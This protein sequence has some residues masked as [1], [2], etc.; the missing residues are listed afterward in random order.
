[1]SSGF[2][3]LNGFETEQFLERR[4]RLRNTHLKIFTLECRLS[5]DSSSQSNGSKF[6]DFLQFTAL[7]LLFSYYSTISAIRIN[8]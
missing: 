8:H 3:E 1:M 2:R 6:E 4:H 5:F 7:I